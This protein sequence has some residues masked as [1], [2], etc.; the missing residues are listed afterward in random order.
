MP[1][2]IRTNLLGLFEIMLVNT[3]H[4]NLFP[5]LVYQLKYVHIA[6]PD[7]KC[8]SFSPPKEWGHYTNHWFCTFYSPKLELFPYGICVIFFLK[9]LLPAAWSSTTQRTWSWSCWISIKN[10]WP[11]QHCVCAC[12]CA[13]FVVCACMR[14]CVCARMCAQE[15]LL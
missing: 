5:L 6:D 8:H 13:C 10:V 14:A 12:A 15:S 7:M 4:L 1:A 9:E 11:G 2:E 3:C